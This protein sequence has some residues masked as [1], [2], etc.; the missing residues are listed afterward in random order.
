M[1]EDRYTLNEARQLLAVD[2]CAA[3]G[4]DVLWIPLRHEGDPDDAI[5]RY[6]CLRCQA[7]CTIAYPLD[8]AT[9]HDEPLFTA[10]RRMALRRQC[11]QPNTYKYIKE[12]HALVPLTERKW[13]CARCDALITFQETP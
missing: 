6:Q 9:Q 8:N 10:Q 5:R 1:T 7:L 4:H 13:V 11:E 2:Q 3:Q 12:G